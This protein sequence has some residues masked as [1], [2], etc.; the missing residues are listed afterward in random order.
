[1]FSEYSLISVLIIQSN[2]SEF[3]RLTQKKIDAMGFFLCALKI[4]YSAKYSDNLIL[5]AWSGQKNDI[6]VYE[7]K[8]KNINHFFQHFLNIFPF[9]LFPNPFFYF[10][11]SAVA[12][13]LFSLSSF[14]SFPFPIILSLSSWHSHYIYFYR[15]SLEGSEHY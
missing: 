12:P 6:V 3:I 13:Y 8:P 7:P 2:F 1:M 11:F 14:S 15:V 9:L 4:F 10:P 5:V